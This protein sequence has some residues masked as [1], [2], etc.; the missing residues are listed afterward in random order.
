MHCSYRVIVVVAVPRF[1]VR[2]D[3]GVQGAEGKNL[4]EPANRVH[5]VLKQYPL[6]LLLKKAVYSQVLAV[7]REDN[8]L[9]LRFSARL[10]LSLIHI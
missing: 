3:A 10:D 6:P 5:L 7:F 8:L 2:R 9:C 1:G 4:P